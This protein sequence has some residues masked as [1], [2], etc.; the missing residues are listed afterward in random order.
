[1]GVGRLAGGHD[2]GTV[3]ASNG[4]GVV[5]L[6]RPRGGRGRRVGLYTIRTQLAVWPSHGRTVPH[7][8]ACAPAGLQP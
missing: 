1:M 7:V 2:G 4:V 6:D 5:Y 3:L 8:H